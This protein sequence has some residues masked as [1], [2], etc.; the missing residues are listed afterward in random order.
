MGCY[1]ELRK[2]YIAMSNWPYA[3]GAPAI[4]EAFGIAGKDPVR[5]VKRQLE[6]EQFP[7][8]LWIDHGACSGRNAVP[9][10][11]IGTLYPGVPQ[12]LSAYFVA[13]KGGDHAAD[14]DGER[15]LTRFFKVEGKVT[16]L[17]VSGAEIVGLLLAGPTSSERITIAWPR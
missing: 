2:G 17:A 4:A 6:K 8:A 3:V 11:E 5:Q 10:P 14:G 9:L 7:G 1:E 13:P 12:D 15:N 16:N